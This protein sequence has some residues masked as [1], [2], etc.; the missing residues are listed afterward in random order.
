[1]LPAFVAVV[2]LCHPDAVPFVK[3]ALAVVDAGTA[4]IV[5]E[6]CWLL[7]RSRKAATV[8]GAIAAIDPFFV[9]SVVDVRTE[10]LFM[11][12]MT[13]GIL[14]LLRSVRTGEQRSAFLGGAAFAAAALTRPAG[15]AALGL[16]GI[17]LLLAHGAR[18]GRL[19]QA[20]ILFG[21]GTTS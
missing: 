18:K 5:G 15:L 13:V 12:F 6:I 16:G 10:P 7:F 2:T 4:L 9:L 1:M 11:F 3:V 20:C 17:A 8:A 19:M 21:G 14:L